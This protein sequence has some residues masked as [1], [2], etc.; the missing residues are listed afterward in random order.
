MHSSYTCNIMHLSL[1]DLTF[2]KVLQTAQS[3]EMAVKKASDVTQLE[4]RLLADL[5]TFSTPNP[6]AC[7]RC[8]K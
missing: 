1:V 8:G 5:N 2:E 3:N 4:V 7:Y 6:T